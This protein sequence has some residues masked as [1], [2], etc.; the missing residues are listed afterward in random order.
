MTWF[1]QKQAVESWYEILMDNVQ[2]LWQMSIAFST[3]KI[4][5]LKA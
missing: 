2:N 3:A 4:F 1:G 5:D